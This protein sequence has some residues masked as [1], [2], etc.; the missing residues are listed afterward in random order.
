MLLAIKNHLETQFKNDGFGLNQ[1]YA[2]LNCMLEITE[3]DLTVLCGIVQLC[4]WL[5]LVV[6]DAAGGTC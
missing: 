6:L 3:W 2:C 5:F 1:C 4:L